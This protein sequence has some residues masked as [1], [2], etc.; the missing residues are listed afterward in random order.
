MVW[1]TNER[2]LLALFPAGTIARAPHHCK[3][4]TCHKQ[5]L[6]LHSQSSNFVEWNWDVVTTIT[7]WRHNSDSNRIRTNNDLARKQTLKHFATLAK[8]LS[9]W[10]FIYELS[11]CGFESRCCHLIMKYQFEKSESSQFISILCKK[12][13]WQNFLIW[14][15]F[16][17]SLQLLFPRT[18]CTFITI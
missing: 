2:C 6:N 5:D 16:L 14:E 9:D 4:L 7:P 18:N 12:R 10:A 15:K 17:N 1:L 11:G 3:S 8:W 13:I